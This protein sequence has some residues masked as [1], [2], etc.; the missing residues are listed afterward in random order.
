M[1]SQVASYIWNDGVKNPEKLGGV[2][3]K[4]LDLKNEVEGAFWETASIN[5]Q[6]TNSYQWLKIVWAGLL[7]CG[8]AFLV[9]PRRSLF[10]LV[11]LT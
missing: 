11:I 5:L 9:R 7:P 2:V 8:V 10:L 6:Q 3:Q 4:M 1:S